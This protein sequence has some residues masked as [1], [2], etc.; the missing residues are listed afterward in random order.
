MVFAKKNIH[1]DMYIIY[2]IYKYTLPETGEH[3]PPFEKGK[4]STLLSAF[5]K[6]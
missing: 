4:S 2:R 1:I 5:K 3:I 6:G